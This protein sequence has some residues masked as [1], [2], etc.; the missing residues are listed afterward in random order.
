[1]A[2]AFSILTHVTR[3]L[4]DQYRAPGR[5]RSYVTVTKLRRVASNLDC[6]ARVRT[7]NGTLSQKVGGMLKR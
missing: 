1:M 3:L 7:P 4:A 2:E 6:S 5:S